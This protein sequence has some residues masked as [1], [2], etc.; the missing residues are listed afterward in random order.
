[1]DRRRSRPL[2]VLQAL[3]RS[4]ATS[5]WCA[6]IST[7]CRDNAHWRG[8]G[9]REREREREMN[10]GFVY[11][12]TWRDSVSETRCTRFTLAHA[13]LKQTHTMTYNKKHTQCVS[14]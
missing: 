8:G 13:C 12:H 11:S 7:P 9:G 2:A 6:S 14:V 5:R 3:L 10:G 1:M 4:F